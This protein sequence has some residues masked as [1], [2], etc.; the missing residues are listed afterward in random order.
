[1]KRR[2]KDWKERWMQRRFTISSS[3]RYCTGYSVRQT[4]PVKRMY[5]SFIYLFYLNFI[6]YLFVQRKFCLC[7]VIQGE[8]LKS[9]YLSAK[10]YMFEL[11]ICW[12]KPVLL[13]LLTK[14]CNDKIYLYFVKKFNINIILLLLNYKIYGLLSADKFNYLNYKIYRIL[15]ADKFN[16]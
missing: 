2:W 4:T 7:K 14:F 3:S 6:F 13:C 12:L 11:W 5:L 16:C 1:M 8:R 15:C 10:T 9:L